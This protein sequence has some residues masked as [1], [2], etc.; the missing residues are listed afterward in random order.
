MGKVEA[1]ENKQRPGHRGGN[2]E[3]PGE[4]GT[5][6]RQEGPI[7]N[8]PLIL[9]A[10]GSTCVWV[11]LRTSDSLSLRIQRDLGSENSVRHRCFPRGP[12][13]STGEDPMAVLQS[14]VPSPAELILCL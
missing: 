12:Q 13:L 5:E 4:N 7:T 2:R 14:G 11:L 10:E 1:K 6:A 8:L 3:A 9:R